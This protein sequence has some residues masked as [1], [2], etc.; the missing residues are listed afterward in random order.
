MT[1][2][3]TLP[4]AQRQAD[5]ITPAFTVPVDVREVI[6]RPVFDQAT[7]Q[8]ITFLWTLRL[9]LEDGTLWRELCGMKVIGD[10]S[11]DLSD[12]DQ[13]PELS[14]DVHTFI[15]RRIR[16]FINTNKRV[17]YSCELEVN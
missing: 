4:R 15:G 13:R 8:D 16:G 3:A 12:P 9:E 7:L 17:A 5:V 10:M 2:V 11:V 1:I 14:L 6:I